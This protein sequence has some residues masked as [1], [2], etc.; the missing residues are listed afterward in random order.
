MGNA[1]RSYKRN[2]QEWVALPWNHKT[3]PRSKI[4]LH[5]IAAPRYISYASTINQE[6]TFR[7]GPRDFDRAGYTL[8]YGE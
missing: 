2:D 4:V 6:A 5:E 7:A 1:M 8:K 3:K